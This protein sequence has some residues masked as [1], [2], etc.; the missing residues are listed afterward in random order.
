VTSADHES[1]TTAPPHV[2]RR[3]HALLDDLPELSGKPRTISALEGGLTN[4]NFKVSTPERTAV[5]R[6]S[7]SDGD[8]LAID[9]EAEHVNSLRAAESGAAPA[10]LAYRP[11]HQALVVAWLNGTTLTA[12]DLLDERNVIRA[13]A[14]CKQLHSGPRFVGDFDMFEVQRRYLAIVQDRGYRM[15]PRYLDLL[16]EVDRIA[17]ALAVRTEPT[18]PC[19]NDLLAANFIDDGDRLW[20]ID[21]EY[22]GNNDPCFELGN[23]WSESDLPLD[24]LTLLV[25][26]YYGRHLRNKVAR[27]RLLGLMAKYGWTL[28]ASIQA[29]VSPIEFD[30][31]SWG[32]EK[33]E[34]AV[35]EF[36]SPGFPLLLDEARRPD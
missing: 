7:S 8:L 12:Q 35:D 10:V 23:I 16:P 24:H 26:S 5:V 17:D 3:L 25:D 21:Y 13:A 27:A 4:F 33:Y 30:F 14:V 19:N 11:D 20:V 32:M 31:W 34:R 22:A 6:L 15:P 29:T 28:W 9:R 18:V 2:V 1:S 36:D